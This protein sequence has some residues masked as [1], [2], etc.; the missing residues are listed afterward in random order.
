MLKLSGGKSG[1][2]RISFFTRDNGA[3]AIWNQNGEIT[4]EYGKEN[5]SVTNAITVLL[6]TFATFSLIKAFVLIPLMQKDIIGTV[7]YLIPTFFYT[8]LVV[9]VII[10]SRKSDC[11]EML[12]NHGAEHKVLTAYKKLGRIPTVEEADRFSRINKA[13]GATIYSAF[14]T[15]QLIGFAV[16]LN[17]SYIIPEIILFII[18]LFFNT[19]FPFNV[20]GKLVQFF[21]TSKPERRNIE[22]AIAALSALERKERFSDI[23]FDSFSNIYRN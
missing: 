9:G 17:T 8:F 20:I 16:Y 21:T 12:K 14:I 19:I 13:C 2:D 18:P 5:V 22:L 1:K 15:T 4:I 11:Y 3:T 6:R 23:L 10:E 7:W